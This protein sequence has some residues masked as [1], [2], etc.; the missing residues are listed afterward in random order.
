[1]QNPPIITAWAVKRSGPSLT[2]NGTGQ[3]GKPAKITGISLVVPSATVG[4]CH[5]KDRTGKVMASLMN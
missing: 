1:M 2:V 4:C 5:A 3:D